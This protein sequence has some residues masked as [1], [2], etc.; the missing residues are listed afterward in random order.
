MGKATN[1]P[2]VDL[3]KGAKNDD[4]K[5]RL[6]LIDPGLIRELGL[7]LTYGAKKY[8]PNNWRKFDTVNNAEDKE[9]MLSA[10]L[11]HLMADLEGEIFDQESHLIHQAQVA[12]YSMVRIRNILDY[13][14]TNEGFNGKREQI[15]K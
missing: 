5:N 12:F 4:G 9:R 8:A 6:A 3:T 14:K 13:I 11:R 15:G 7:V 10:Q 1:T 2:S